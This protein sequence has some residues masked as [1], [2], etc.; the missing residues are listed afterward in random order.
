MNIV[1]SHVHLPT[2]NRSATLYMGIPKNP[3]THIIYVH[4]AQ[5]IFSDKAAS[6]NMGW[7][8]HK[9]LKQLGLYHVL[10]A[11]VNCAEGYARLDEYAPF[12]IDYAP[13]K[14]TPAT[15]GL[16]DDYLADLVHTIIPAVENKYPIDSAHRMLMGSSMGG[17]ISLYAGFQ[18]PHIFPRIASLSGAY[19]V[20]LKAFQNYFKQTFT[21]TPQFVYLD[22]GDHEEGLSDQSGY[23]HAHAILKVSL[24][25][26]LK[27]EQWEERIIPGGQHNEIH[28]HKR[29]PRILQSLLIQAPE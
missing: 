20:S 25:K 1:E 29:L 27:A 15:G 7:N 5:N 3:V 26:H 2:L 13:L 23:L 28:W 6:Y 11:G 9:V 17:I 4:D 16:G 19:Y 24:N 14:K 21:Q 22:V 12:A 18:Y 10:V 8:I